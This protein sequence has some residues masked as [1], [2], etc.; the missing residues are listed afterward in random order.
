M[1]ESNLPSMA[2]WKKLLIW[3]GIFLGMTCI[4]MFLI[5]LLAAVM[6]MGTSFLFCSSALQA[7]VAF[8]GTSLIT[9]RL[10][11]TS[12]TPYKALALDT[13]PS[14]K[15]LFIMVMG[16]IIA[17][18]ALNQIIWWNSEMHL[19]ESMA[20]FEQILRTLEEQNS[21]VAEQMLAG[22]SIGSLI[23]GIL[24]VGLLTGIAEELLFRGSLQRILAGACGSAAAIWIAAFIFS[25]IHF[26]F[27][28]FV[29]RLLLGAWFGYLLFWSK[30]V[31]TS[32]IA[33]ALN[34][35]IVVVCTWLAARGFE[36]FEAEQI[37]VV[38]HGFPWPALISACA[39]AVFIYL[40][41]NKS[42]KDIQH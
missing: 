17:I 39:F 9:A 20:G 5:Q 31:W 4:T 11:S 41:S 14:A 33:H 18:P 24:I 8:I 36:P 29:P 7:L 23:F 22:S 13:A 2:T 37:G 38:H 21:A 35:S 10:T 34:N 40:F 15:A 19:P 26:Q 27:F 30:S 6:P 42:S 1:T 32:A 25:T 16:Y 28:G 3:F 12:Q